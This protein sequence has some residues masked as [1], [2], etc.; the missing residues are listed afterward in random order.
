MK[1]DPDPVALHH[2]FE[3]AWR[4]PTGWRALSAVNHSVI[5]LRFMVTAVVFFLIGGL[6]AM[7]IRS[8]LATAES[9]WLDPA[10]YAQVFTMH[11]T[12]MMFLFAIPLIEGLSLYLLPKLLGSRDLAFPMLSA[13]GYWC[14]LFGGIILLIALVAGAAPDGG[15]FMY[16]P[17][18]SK[19]HSP[20][21]NADVWLLGVT[22][23]EV[24]AICAAV[25]FMATVLK[26]R[27]AGMTFG[28]MPLMVWYLW[29][30]AAMMLF[31]FPPLILGSILLEIERAFG[32]VFFDPDRGGDPLL[33]QHLFW[34][35]GHPEVYI[36]FLPAAGI[37]TTI[38]ASLSGRPIIGYA[39]IV[40]ALIA[41]GF[42]SF[43]LWAHHMFTTG[44]PALALGFFS[45]ASLLV[46]IPTAVQIFS[47]LGTLWTGRPRLELPMY[48]VLGFLFVFI[49]GG[50]TGIMVALVPFDVQAHD[51]YFVVAHLHYVLVGGFL[52]PI[53]AGLYYW[54]PHLTGNETYPVLGKTAFWL[55]FLGFNVAFL[56]MHWTG[57]IG[58]RR[59]IDTYEAGDGFELLNTIS[60]VS[61]FVLAIGIALVLVDTILTV[62]FSRRSV[63][64][65]WAAP[66]LEWHMP[67]PV[68]PYNIASQPRIADRH[69]GWTTPDLGVTLAG[70]RGYLAKVRHGWRETL[71]VDARTA[72][73]DQIL[74]LPSPTFIPLQTALSL[75]LFVVCVLFGQYLVSLLGLVGVGI[76]VWRW[77]W[78]SGSRRDRGQLQIGLDEAAPVHWEHPAPP[79]YWGLV[80][81][82][83]ADATM[84]GS[85]IFG[86][87]FLATAA[88][89]W[90]PETVATPPLWL[91]V[92]AGLAALLAAIAA[93]RTK[94]PRSGA[95]LPTGLMMAAGASAIGVLA[96][97]AAA[98][99]VGPMA[100]DH[101][102]F[103]AMAT[104]CAFGAFHFFVGTVMAVYGIARQ[105]AG[106]VSTARCVE[107]RSHALWQ[108]YSAAVALVIVG[109]VLIMQ[110]MVW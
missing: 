86:V 2:E 48:Y 82:I 58:M 103:A 21:I 45:F 68:A 35:F 104:L 23:V 63:R 43:L 89:N 15:W 88:P 101:A 83:L 46:V 66:T 107:Y 28:R 97:G 47:W 6:L 31:G 32:W 5:G 79:S 110:H 93:L 60:S 24:S 29:I 12:I 100:T 69:P 87:L 75:G 94:A 38:I 44:I 57:L 13:F 25:E 59:R 1:T 37:V 50:L 76:C 14:Y 91:L 7:M 3:Q 95:G 65:P 96:L 108:G 19:T 56:P 64:N 41:L 49:A 71:C 54:L 67:F 70:G 74:V 106:Y 10:S 4:A 8:Q 40:L 9:N 84:F 99:S 72:E 11:G 34:L 55:I 17:L 90:P 39:W 22:F 109:L 18:S 80:F 85:L 62:R 53:L 92:T 73:P 81:T 30:T 51:T 98:L 20:G 36:I 26:V 77:L 102:V 42:L 33:W 78:R 27:T 16:V 61:G 105:S 52:F